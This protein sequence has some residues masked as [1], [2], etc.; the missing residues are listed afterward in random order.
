[1]R[2]IDHVSKWLYKPVWNITN[3]IR[4]DGE[5]PET[6]EMTLLVWVTLLGFLAV[7][8]VAQKPR[9]CMT[10]LRLQGTVAVTTQQ[11]SMRA[12]ANYN[13][14]AVNQRIQVTATGQYDNTNFF[15]EFLLLY[16]E[17]VM[18]EIHPVERTCTKTPLK[19]FHPLNIP[20]NA[21]LLSHEVLGSLH[22]GLQANTWIGDIPEEQ[23][24]YLLTFTKFGCFPVSAVYN[25][26]NLGFITASFF[27]NTVNNE[28]WHVFVPPKYCANAVFEAGEGVQFFSIF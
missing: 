17:G 22:N 28:D 6:E 8:S 27:N 24:Q 13:Y 9:P 12:L 18:Y 20:Y 5:I 1:M 26:P 21:Y 11:H 14:D 10:P 25:D 19:P 16:K 23:A 15:V 2:E 7:H 3:N 4:D